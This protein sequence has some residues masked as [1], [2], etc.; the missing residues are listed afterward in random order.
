MI[1][2]ALPHTYISFDTAWSTPEPI[3]VQLSKD[4]PEVEMFILYADEDIGYNYGA[5]IMKM[6]IKLD[7][8]QS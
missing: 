7:H 4:L 5:Y 3:I 8:Y 1:L 2:N 6:V